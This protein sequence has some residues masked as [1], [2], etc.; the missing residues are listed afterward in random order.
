[1]N[2]GIIG[3]G[4]LGFSMG[5]IWTEKGHQVCFSYSR[6]PTTLAATVAASGL[7]ASLCTPIQAAQFANVVL[8]AVHWPQVSQIVADIRPYMSG[9]TLLTCVMPWRADYSGLLFGT[10]TSAA[11][12]IA[13]L[14]PEANL[15]EAFPLLADGLQL[16][17]PQS[18]TDPATIFY[19]GDDADAKD[20]V[21]GLLEDLGLQPADVGDLTSARLLEPVMALFRKLAIGQGE[22]ADIVLKLT[23][24]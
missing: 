10:D 15:V 6:S 9:K 18:P 16:P 11:E 4:H 8:L 14:V 7:N 24:R 21:A 5:N 22:G 13:R 3:S 12:E 1:M 23:R 19:C 20:D 17:T 2:I